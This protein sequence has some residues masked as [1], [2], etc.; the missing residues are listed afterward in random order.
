MKYFMSAIFIISYNQM[1]AKTFKFE[2]LT[3]I[4]QIMTDFIILKVFLSDTCMN[5]TLS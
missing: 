3:L 4:R 5:Y 1:A 2:I